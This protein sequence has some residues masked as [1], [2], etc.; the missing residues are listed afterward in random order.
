MAE[1]RKVV[2]D[3]EFN[4]D[5][6]VKEV[7]KLEQGIS[8]AEKGTKSFG[9]TLKSLGSTAGIFG[10][11]ATAITTMKEALENN[12]KV[13]D[14][15]KTTTT[16]LGIVVNDL[17][18]FIIDN[19]GGVV[20]VFD[21]IFKDP[22]QSIKDLGNA[23]QENLVERFESYIETLGLVG[24]AIKQVFEGDF[25]G[26]FETAK[27]AGKEAVD[28]LTG[29]DGSF[30]K[31]VDGAKAA[32][33]AVVN[34]GKDVVTT[35]QDIVQ[36]EKDLIASENQRA[37]LQL[38]YQKKAEDQRQIRDDVT[39]S[40]SERIKA[41]EEL[42]KILQ[43][44]IKLEQDAV[45]QAIAAKQK[46]LQL[47]KD[48]FTLQQELY[49]LE[50]E[51]IDIKERV[52]GQEAEQKE[53]TNALLQEELDLKNEL[54]LVGL[55]DEE[56]EELALEQ[57]RDRLNALAEVAYESEEEKQ[58]KLLDIQKWYA[59]EKKKLSDAQI[60]D[61]EEKSK[62]EVANEKLVA[63]RKNAI[64]T[65]AADVAMNLT[66]LVAETGL[67]SAQQAFNIQ[68]GLNIAQAA[69]DTAGA[70]VKVLKETTDFTPT[71]SLRTAAAIAVG[72]TGAAQIA[73]IASQQFNA[74]SA[75]NSGGG[76]SGG[77]T[78]API[79]TPDYDAPEFNLVGDGGT[80]QLAG[81]I[82]N[83]NQTPVRAYVTTK[84]INSAEEMDRNTQNASTL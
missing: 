18:N 15:F 76:G 25:S 32:G 6:S 4:A 48:N 66:A 16:A 7:N 68:K 43:D 41:N 14:F 52:G 8:K 49:Q 42:G 19:A 20:D 23:I 10:L 2:Y 65:A 37:R 28:V 27:E 39:R 35:A 60:K 36:A 77:A 63:D 58:Q 70:V 57:E 40:I 34:Y 47:D 33:E 82:N 62:E 12:Q 45:N 50:T 64:Q 13:L 24:K 74:E 46:E 21:A 3:I 81:A 80:N 67:V 5:G 78:T 79:T 26:A 84:D 22:V 83:Q 54:A 73:L 61:V 59:D 72:A 1:D 9:K 55:S 17:F 71:Q 11:I 51:L 69:V 44:Q 31:I 75:K 38:E 56:Q 29:V 30:D 53:Q